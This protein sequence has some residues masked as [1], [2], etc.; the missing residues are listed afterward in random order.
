[1][2]KACE[3]GD[4]SAPKDRLL[5]CLQLCVA[6]FQLQEQGAGQGAESDSLPEAIE[7]AQ[8]VLGSLVDRMTQ[9]DLEDFELVGERERGRRERCGLPLS[10]TG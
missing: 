7:E 3:C 9:T 8:E 6:K 1:M 5:Q 10:I 4:F 2:H